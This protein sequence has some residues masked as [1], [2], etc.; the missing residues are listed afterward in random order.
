MVA[1]EIIASVE[2]ILTKEDTAEVRREEV[3]HVVKLIM[4]WQLGVMNLQQNGG[5][6]QA[7]IDWLWE[8]LREVL[9]EVPQE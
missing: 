6:R 4:T 3:E 1:K 9:K 8:L 2:D 7:M 5:R